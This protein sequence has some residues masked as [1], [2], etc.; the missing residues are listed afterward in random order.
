MRPFF[1]I[2][3]L[4]LGCPETEPV[5]QTCEGLFGA[6]SENT[7]LSAS[8]CESVCHCGES[9]WQP[10]SISEETIASFEAATLLDGPQPLTEDPYSTTPDAAP[11]ETAFCSI[12]RAESGSTSYRLLATGS[13]AQATEAGASITHKGACGLCSSLQ[14][15]AV[16]LRNPDLT[17]P[18]RE[19][20]LQGMFEGEQANIDCLMAIGFDLPCA[21]I[22]TYN[23]NHTRQACLEPCLAALEDPHHNPDGSLNDCIQCDE[24]QSGAVFKA[25]A[26]RTRRNSGLASALCRPC[27]SV[28]QVSHD[29]F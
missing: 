11:D 28:Y 7:G 6:P 1:L 21:Q 15:L 12:L 26:G 20:G 17:D 25:V 27:D 8:Q 5:D 13:E 3:L 16:Y 19:C 10:P 23:T 14:N 9:A 22:W 18:V 4:F 24:D 2:A 29:A